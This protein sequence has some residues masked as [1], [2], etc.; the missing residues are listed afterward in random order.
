MLN[1]KINKSLGYIMGFLIPGV[2]VVLINLY[3][4]ITRSSSKYITILSNIFFIIMFLYL[5]IREVMN[6]RK[7]GYFFLLIVATMLGLIYR[8]SR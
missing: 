6:K 7:I 3:G 2:I 1:M 8:H 4:L 5:G